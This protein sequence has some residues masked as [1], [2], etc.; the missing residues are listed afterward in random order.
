L[1]KPENPPLFIPVILSGVKNLIRIRFQN[2][3]SLTLAARSGSVSDRYFITVWKRF[4]LSLALRASAQ[5]DI[6]NRCFCIAALFS[7]MGISCSPCRL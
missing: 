5:N 2:Y 6:Q 3:R 1:R 7:N 4:V